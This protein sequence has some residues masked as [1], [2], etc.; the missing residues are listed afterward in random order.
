[1]CEEALS[2]DTLLVTAVRGSLGLAV[3][4]SAMTV[5]R[6]NGTVVNPRCSSWKP[7]RRSAGYR[8]AAARRGNFQPGR[9]K[10]QV[11]PLG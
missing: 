8:S 3:S 7:C 11:Y 1:M 6:E 4:A 9:M 5:G 10:W 2:G